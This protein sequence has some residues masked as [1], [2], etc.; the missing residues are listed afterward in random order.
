MKCFILL[1]NVTFLRLIVGT[2]APLHQCPVCKGSLRDL[3]DWDCG[4]PLLSDLVTGRL[5][6][7]W[8]FESPGCM[9]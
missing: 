7:A 1:P 4:N 5:R 2:F 3:D 8:T 6:I 9:T